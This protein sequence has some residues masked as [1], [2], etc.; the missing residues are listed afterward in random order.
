MRPKR[1]HLLRFFTAIGG[2]VV[3]VAIGVTL[4]L[5]SNWGRGGSNWDAPALME[6]LDC[7]VASICRHFPG[8][9]MRIRDAAGGYF[10]VTANDLGFRVPAPPPPDPDASRFVVQ[11]YGDSM[12]YGSGVDDSETIAVEMQKILARRLPERDVHVM[13]FGMPMNYLRSQLKIYQTWGRRYRPDIV[14]FEYHG[15]IPNPRDINFRVQQIRDSA[16]LGFLFRFAVGRDLINRYQ[17]WSIALYDRDDALEALRPGVDQV[18]R[19]RR[20]RGLDVAVFSFVSNFDDLDEIFPQDLAV[21]RIP[22]GLQGWDGYRASNYI[23]PG[24]GHPSPR[25][26]RLFAERIVDGLRPFLPSR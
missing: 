15:D 24:D 19:D 4:L 8:Q 3:G 18:A 17:T 10:N 6:F 20:E 5:Q 2:I 13:N 1:D 12:I 22:S 23:I 7:S 9:E 14:V 16:I 11:I 26:T 21:A 25:G